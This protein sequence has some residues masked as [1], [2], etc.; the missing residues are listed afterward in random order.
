MTFSYFKKSAF[1]CKCGC[2]TKLFGKDWLSYPTC[3][4]CMAK[5]KRELDEG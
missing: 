5:R 3:K 4:S 1:T 2:K